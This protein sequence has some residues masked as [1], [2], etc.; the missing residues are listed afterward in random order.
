MRCHRGA[1]WFHQRG[2]RGKA[3]GVVDEVEEDIDAVG[4]CLSD[5]VWQRYRCVIDRFGRT[6]YA[7][8]LS[9]GGGV[10]GGRGT[11]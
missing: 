1:A 7:D 9:G 5:R 10:G 11:Q 8:P 2:E 3:G 4:V 6:V